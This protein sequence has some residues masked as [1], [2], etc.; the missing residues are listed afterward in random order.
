MCLLVAGEQP[1]GVSF[2]VCQLL[3]IPWAVVAV[4]GDSVLF[5]TRPGRLAP[6]AA[7]Y[8]QADCENGS[9]VSPMTRQ[10][11]GPHA[12]LQ[13]SSPLIPPWPL[14]FLTPSLRAW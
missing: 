9:H 10:S 14:L 3:L 1:P 7:A 6:V 11:P 8:E 12:S 13:T 5:P 2:P 4:R